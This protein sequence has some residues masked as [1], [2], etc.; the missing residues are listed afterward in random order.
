MSDWMAGIEGLNT[1]AADLA[2][3]GGTAGAAGI[4]LVRTTALL[5]EGA[6]KAFA[7]VDT[8]ALRSSIGTDVSVAIASG[9]AEAV[10]GP[11]VN[12]G[13]FVEYGTARMAPRAFMGPALDRHSGTFIAGVESLANPLP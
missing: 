6:A 13:P 2:K 12:Y 1:V 4:T 7:P 5:I 8:G 9:A 10:I 3:A 11:T